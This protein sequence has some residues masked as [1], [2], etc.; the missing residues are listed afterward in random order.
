MGRKA[1]MPSREEVLVA[2]V[3]LTLQVEHG[4]QPETIEILVEGFR[5]IVVTAAQRIL[6]RPEGPGV[7]LERETLPQ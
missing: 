2:A 5:P 6:L 4:P 1:T 7:V 3:P